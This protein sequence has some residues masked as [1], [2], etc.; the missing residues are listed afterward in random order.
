MAPDC[1]YNAVA[2][3]IE[4]PLFSLFIRVSMVSV[5]LDN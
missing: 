4:A 1:I 2:K 3:M 5:D